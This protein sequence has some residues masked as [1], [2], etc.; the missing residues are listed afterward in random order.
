MRAKSRNAVEILDLRAIHIPS[1]GTGLSSFSDHK[2]VDHSTE[3]SVQTP[4]PAVIAFLTCGLDTIGATSPFGLGL[5][6][7]AAC[8]LGSQKNMDDKQEKQRSEADAELERE[9]REGR[10]FT[11][12][13][14]IARMVGPGGM[15]GESPVTRMQ[16]A[17]VEIGSWLRTHLGDASGALEVVLHRR[18]KGCELLLNNYDQPMVVLAS[19]C[20]RILDSDYQLEELVRD[21]DIEWGRVMGERPYFERTGSARHPD[22]PYTVESVRNILSGLLKELAAGEY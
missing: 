4:L 14:A 6:D 7:D 16:Q 20:Q 11:L 10:K 21:A 13:E 17:E 8:N 15:K 18:V 1:Q 5:T 9:I 22:D 2:V 12:E 19:Y 3:G